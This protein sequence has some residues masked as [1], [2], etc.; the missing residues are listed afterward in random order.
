MSNKPSA[1][2]RLARELGCRSDEASQRA[3]INR[4]YYAS[5]HRC[6]AWEGAFRRAAHA[7]HS[8]ASTLN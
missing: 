2:H 8:V 3:S 7:I 1:W 4:A 5:Y 6:L